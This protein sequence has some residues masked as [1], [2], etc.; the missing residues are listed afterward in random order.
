MRIR[1]HTGCSDEYFKR[2]NLNNISEIASIEVAAELDREISDFKNVG[3]LSWTHSYKF[4]KQGPPIKISQ[5][6]F[7]ETIFVLGY[8][9]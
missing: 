9:T 8:L 3:G 7:P 1:V 4:I 6:T 5:L 2:G